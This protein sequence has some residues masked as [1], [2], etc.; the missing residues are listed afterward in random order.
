MVFKLSYE[1]A[2]TGLI[3]DNSS[4]INLIDGIEMTITSKLLKLLKL[5]S[6][7][8][9]N[10]CGKKHWYRNNDPHCFFLKTD[11]WVKSKCMS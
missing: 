11:I 7:W 3:I 8:H 1:N 4:S 6:N 10:H 2:K 9:E 5:L